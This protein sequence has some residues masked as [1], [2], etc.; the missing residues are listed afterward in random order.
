MKTQVQHVLLIGAVALASLNGGCGGG[1]AKDTRNTTREGLAQTVPVRVQEIQPQPFTQTI[2]LTG[3][4]KAIDD[5][6][7]SPEDGGVVRQWR[8]LK[9]QFVRKGDVIVT[10]SDDVAK[11]SYDAA[12]AQY[13]AAQLTYEKQEKVYSEQAVSEVQLKTSQYQRDAAKANADLTYARWKRTQI[14]APVSGILDDRLADEGEMAPP[15]VPIARIVRIDRVKLLINVPERY[16]GRIARGTPVTF[17]ISMLPSETYHGSIDFVGAAI[18]ADNRT[19]PIELVL[20]NPGN[21]LKPEMIAQARVIESVQK[22][23]LLL[24][25]SIV[26]LVDR[27]KLVVYVEHEGKAHERVVTIGGRLQD[28]VEIVTGLKPGDRVITSGYQN[29]VDG[30]SVNVVP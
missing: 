29:L 1:D 15:S 5:V 11:A 4:I 6:L 19:F 3:T 10:L 12:L 23:A 20:K 16:A 17:T 8:Y 9:G 21:K 22:D 18:S 27:E 26:Q 2:S 13:H 28:M 14:S 7:V 25:E 30:Q 24:D